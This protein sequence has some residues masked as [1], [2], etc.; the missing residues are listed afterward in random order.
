MPWTAAS[1]KTY[2][3]CLLDTNA[4]SEIV[5]R[6]SRDGRHFVER[7]GPE[8]H[9][10]CFTVYSLL[11][12]RRRPDV[13]RRFIKMFS[14][15]PIFLLKQW[16][17]ILAEERD[18]YSTAASVSSLFQSFTPL[19]SDRT[20]DLG[21]FVDRLGAQEWFVDLERKWRKEEVQIR[22]SWLATRKN[23]QPRRQ[24]ANAQDAERYVNEAAIQ[25]LIS[26]FPDWTR[27]LIERNEVPDV[28]RFPALQVMLY[29]QYYRLWDLNWKP[30]PQEVTD[31]RIMTAAPYVDVVITEGFQNEVFKKIRTRV[32]ALREVDSVPVRQL[33]ESS[34]RSP[35]IESDDDKTELCR[36]R[37]KKE[38]G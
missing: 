33:G 12:V 21:E 25:T 20:Y 38:N 17:E 5:K 3:L 4:L 27:S 16:N 10:P 37:R 35:S 22:D 2:K 34:S 36:P 29:S 19:G 7:F 15:Y 28:S 32:P 18:A 24:V 31:I 14:Q 8:Q 1:G 13:C 26:L 11:E 9:V 30:R 6:P 23:F